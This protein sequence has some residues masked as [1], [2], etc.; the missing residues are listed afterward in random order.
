MMQVVGSSNIY[1]SGNAIGGALG[2]VQST[3]NIE[4]I[5]S[6]S[7]L[8]LA[9]LAGASSM[10][11]TGQLIPNAAG[12]LSGGSLFSIYP[13]GSGSLGI[14]S[15]GS[16]NILLTASGSGTLL[17]G[18]SG[19]SDFYLTA[20]G[21]MISVVSIKGT[22]PIII[23]ATL[24]QE[25]LGWL[26][27][28]TV[29]SL[30]GHMITYGI[31]SMVGTTADLTGLTTT[32]IADAVWQYSFGTATSKKTLEDVLIAVEASLALNQADQ[33]HTAEL[34]T[35][36]D[37][38]TNTLLLQKNVTGSKFGSGTMTMTG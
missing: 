34:I 38:L 30:A 12:Y 25:G 31:G 32:S 27:A 16:A 18:V 9:P 8:S 28:N 10:V 4:V 23:S 22:S 33:V 35:F 14:G 29:V 3:S 37:R 36:R 19:V 1:L 15:L 17:A 20:S 26:N 24:T 21:Q 7:I 5:T 13:E 2:W 6:G 11:I